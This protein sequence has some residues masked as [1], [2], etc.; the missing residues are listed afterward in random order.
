MYYFRKV[1]QGAS[2][3][4]RARAGTTSVHTEVRA[5]VRQH[6]PAC[7]SMH[8]GGISGNKSE[9]FVFLDRIIQ[10][11]VIYYYII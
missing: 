10:C 9:C 8:G 2:A 11:H 6:A 5:S 7:V 3:H 4:A 1:G